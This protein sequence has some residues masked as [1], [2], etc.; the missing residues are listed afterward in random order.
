MTLEISDSLK[1]RLEAIAARTTMSPSE[2]VDDALTKGYSLEWL[3]RSLD[4]VERAKEQA[5]QGEFATA[6]DVARVVN[7]Y[8]PT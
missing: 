5:A 2:L 1:A 8:R 7:K 6:D 4:R 3:E